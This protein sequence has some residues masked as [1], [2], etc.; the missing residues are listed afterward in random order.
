MPGPRGKSKVTIKERK[1]L[2]ARL[3]G[4]TVAA[5]AKIA[6][7][8]PQYTSVVLKKPQ[9]KEKFTELLEKAGLSDD[10]LSNKFKQL[11][12]A[13]EI[14][15][16]SDKGIVTDEREVEA[17]ETQRRTTE[18]IAKLKGHLVEKIEENLAPE[19]L[20]RLVVIP[21]KTSL[22]DWEPPLDE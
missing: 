15:Y 5:A 4:K 9:V 2:K 10:Y 20:A 19:L 22:K 14:K 7:F 13:K 21:Q 11:S 16:F 17:L 6:G 12:S 8:N 18:F 3:E 1:F